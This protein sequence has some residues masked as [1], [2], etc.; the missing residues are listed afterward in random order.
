MGM[1]VI[2]ISGYESEVSL[3]A[4]ALA[5]VAE[6]GVTNLA[7]LRG[8]GMVAVVADGWAFD[9]AN[10]QGAV[11]ALIPTTNREVRT[12]LPVGRMWVP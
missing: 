11:D 5:G 6:L 9:P 1:V 7:L 2:L 12:L 4:D 3:D 8:A 10:S